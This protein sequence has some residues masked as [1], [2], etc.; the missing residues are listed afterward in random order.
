MK[1]RVL[2]FS[3]MGADHR[4]FQ[5]LRLENIEAVYINWIEPKT[6]EPLATYAQRLIH[7]V[8]IKPTD[9]LIGLSL[10]GLIAQEIAATHQVKKVILISSLRSGET[11]QPLFTAAQKLHILKLVHADLLKTTLVN[12]AKIVFRSNDERVKI[13]V[14][15]LDQYS[16]QYYKWAM[17]QVLNWQG[18]NAK[19]PVLHVHGDKDELFPIE[20]V[21][22]AEIIANGTHLMVSLKA[23]EVSKKLQAFLDN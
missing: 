13:M 10:G 17:M 7:K 11:M 4:A 16:G 2:F 6:D 5:F 3:G 8:E 22:E 1:Q 14:E 18:A 23:A 9:V 21:K 19:C 15:M 20:Q 12:G